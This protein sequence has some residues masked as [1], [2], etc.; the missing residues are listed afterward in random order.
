MLFKRNK[1]YNR[2]DCRFFKK[3]EELKEETKK[4][5]EIYTHDI[6]D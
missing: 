3:V 5:E 4:I 6:M 2:I 1:Q